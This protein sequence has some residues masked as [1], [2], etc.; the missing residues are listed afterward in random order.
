MS[1]FDAGQKLQ[2]ERTKQITLTKGLNIMTAIRLGRAITAQERAQITA[3]AAKG[4]AIAASNPAVAAGRA[5]ANG[6]PNPGAYKWGFDIATCLAQGQTLAGPGK[7][8]IKNL[9]GPFYYGSGPDAAANLP[10]SDPRAKG[11]NEAMQGFDVGQTL[12]FGITNSQG[13]AQ[14]KE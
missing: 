10:I 13:S 4:A 8:A 9:L 1:G 2:H 5:L 11:S 3:Y 6:S 7:D 12:Q 14:P